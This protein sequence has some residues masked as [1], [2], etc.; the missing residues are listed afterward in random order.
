MLEAE[1]LAEFALSLRLMAKTIKLDRPFVDLVGTGGDGAGT[2]NLS[3]ASALLTAACGVPVVKHGNRA[4]T[5]KC[6]SADLMES[7]GANLHLDA[8]GI[9]QAVQKTQFAF[10]FAPDFHPMLASVKEERKKL[11]KPTQFN[12]VGPLINPAG[13]DHLL[14]GVY[15]ER[16]VPILARALQILGTKR[17]LVF[18]NYGL[19]ELTCIGPCKATLVTPDAMQ[20]MSFDPDELGLTLCTLDDLKG[21]DAKENARIIRRAL[22]GAKSPISDTLILNAAAA[23]FLY[24]PVGTIEE[25]IKHARSTLQSGAALEILNRYCAS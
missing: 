25:G 15:D 19:D 16:L 4:A 10:C 23:L 20:P 17:S 8:K 5:S 3:T 2:V 13:L 9:Q 21:G 7:F 6:G 12:L 24:G 22:S 18:S 1:E 11:G 14:L